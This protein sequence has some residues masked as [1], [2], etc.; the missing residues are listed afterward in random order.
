MND[1]LFSC[2]ETS[3]SLSHIIDYIFRWHSAVLCHALKP[4]SVSDLDFLSVGF[5]FSVNGQ[6][7]KKDLQVP[8][9]Y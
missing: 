3:G 5:P 7:F 8:N 4:I 1:N 2:L 9:I 6:F